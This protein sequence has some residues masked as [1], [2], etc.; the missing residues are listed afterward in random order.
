MSKG[1]VSGGLNPGS[2]ARRSGARIDKWIRDRLVDWRQLL[3][4]PQTDR[5]RSCE[6]SSRTARRWRAFIRTVTASGWLDR[7]SAPAGRLGLAYS[8][9]S[10]TLSR[11]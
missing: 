11:C 10:V 8:G 3:A 6:P 2:P 7:K 4:V 1:E 9:S 5:H